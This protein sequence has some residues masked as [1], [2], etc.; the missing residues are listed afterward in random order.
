[1]HPQRHAMLAH[2]IPAQHPC[3]QAKDARSRRKPRW[4][5]RIL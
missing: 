5:W 1:M 4:L 2:L 3:R